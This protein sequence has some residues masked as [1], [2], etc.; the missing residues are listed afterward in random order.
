MPRL[1]FEAVVQFH[2]DGPFVDGHL[3]DLYQVTGARRGTALG[4]D[5]LPAL[6]VEVTVG[7]FHQ[8]RR[9]GSGDVGP[10]SG[11]FG[12]QAAQ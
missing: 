12:G 8:Q 9:L 6:L 7:A 4:A 10:G 5:G 3:G 2:H 1:A 11:V